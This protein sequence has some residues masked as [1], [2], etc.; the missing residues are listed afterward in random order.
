M[1]QTK[2]PKNKTKQT[3]TQLEDSSSELLN[4]T[5]IWPL[6]QGI[7]KPL[8]KNFKQTSRS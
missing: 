5:Y 8:D 1:L 4:L 6:D 3:L 7:T 2:Q